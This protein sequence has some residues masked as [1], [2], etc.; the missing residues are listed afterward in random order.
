MS[1][2]TPDTTPVM[3]SLLATVLAEQIPDD[4]QLGLTAALLVQLGDTLATI[5]IT[6]ENCKARQTAQPGTPQ[7][8]NAE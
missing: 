1:C 8:T 4:A 5:A 3:V 2:I 6:R 7:P